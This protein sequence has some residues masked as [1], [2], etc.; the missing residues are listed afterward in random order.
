M[1]IDSP[2]GALSNTGDVLWQT[3]PFGRYSAELLPTRRVT[4]EVAPRANRRPVY[5]TWSGRRRMAGVGGTGV[6]SL[7]RSRRATSYSE[8][9]QLKC[10]DPL[11]GRRWARFRHSRR[12][13]CS[14][15]WNTYLPPDVGG[16]VAHVIRMVTA[17]SSKRTAE[18][19][20]ANDGGRRNIADVGYKMRRDSRLLSNRISDRCSGK[21]MYEHEVPIASRVSV[22]EP[23][24]I[25]VYE[26]AG[27]FRLIDV[28]TGEITI[29]EQLQP[30]ADVQSISTMRSG[31]KLFVMLSNQ[32]NQQFKPLV[33]QTDFPMINGLVYAFSRS[34]GKQLWPAPAVVRNRGIVLSQPQDIPLLVLRIEVVRDAAAGGGSQLRLLCIDQNTGQT[35][36]Q[37]IPCSTR[38]SPAFAFVASRAPAAAGRPGRQ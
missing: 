19:G 6:C 35:V 32:P 36:Y 13:R 15:T 24:A 17:G 29:D 4:T 33:Q 25:A 2:N 3:D 20:M 18:T 30:L 38:R 28:R 26:P 7:G 10:V 27:E 1:A 37:T 34:T 11:S 14:A 8:Q 12:V 23:N 9:D 5:H 21:A 22:M 16:R 31:D